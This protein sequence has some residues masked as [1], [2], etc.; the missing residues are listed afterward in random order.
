MNNSICDTKGN[1]G[2]KGFILVIC[3]IILLLFLFWCW[4][5]S[6]ILIREDKAWLL[7]L[8]TVLI[9][10]DI[11]ISFVRFFI[12]RNS[13]VAVYDTHITGVTMLTFSLTELINTSFTLRYDE[14]LQVESAKNCIVIYTAY[15]K[16][17]VSALNNQKR[18]ETEIRRHIIRHKEANK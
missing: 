15:R 8:V 1:W 12:N 18:A 17:I 11:V 16:Y 6:Y 7:I 5:Y 9:L 14:I 4:K 13:Y 2:T 3:N 10:S